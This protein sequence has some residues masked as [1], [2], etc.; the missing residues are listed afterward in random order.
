MLWRHRLEPLLRPLIQRMF[1]LQRGMTLG[2]RGLVLDGQGRVLMVEHSYQAGWRLPGGGVERG[3]TAVQAMRREL[4]EEGGV[5]VIGEPRLVSIHSQE[6]RFRGD[7]VLLYRID[8][9]APCPPH[10]GLE[11]ARIDW[12]DPAALPASVS[13]GTRRRI[14]EALGGAPSDPLW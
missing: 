12:F 14:A 6:Q 7:H 5:R 10:G 8:A 1:R 4:E 13:E 3:E 11:I 9:W 2:V